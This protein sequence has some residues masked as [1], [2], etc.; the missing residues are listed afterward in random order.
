MWCK[1]KD[2]NKFFLLVSNNAEEGY[3][4]SS[5]MVTELE[6]LNKNACEK[7]EKLK[8]EEE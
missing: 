8:K 6:N 5:S 2:T 7:Y 3:K 4:N 1:N